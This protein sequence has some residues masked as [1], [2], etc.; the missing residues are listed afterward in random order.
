MRDATCGTRRL[1]RAV[2]WLATLL[3]VPV[4]MLG[5]QR[6]RTAVPAP[7]QELP[8]NL[9][10]FLVTLGEGKYYWEKFGHNALW[11]YDPTRGIDI[12][13]NWGTFDFGDP[14][15][16]KR[17]LTADTRYWVE[18]VPGPVFID[19]YQRSDRSITV[20]RLNFTAGQAD[21]AFAFAQWNAQDANKYYQYDYFRDNCSTRVRDVIDR[22]LGGALRQATGRRLTE[23]TYRL[24]SLRLV[25]DMKLTQFGINTALGQP[26]D[27][28]LTEWEAMFVPSTMQLA[29]REL[30]V[31]GGADGVLI[32]I[33]TD[34]RVLYESTQHQERTT[35]PG[36]AMPYLIVGLLLAAELF[37]VARAG[38]RRRGVEILFRV[39]AAVWA[40]V[41]GLLGT[42]VL[43]AWLLTQ[44]VFWFRNENL[45]LLNP[46]ALFLA[47]LVPLSLWRPR[48]TR[49][50]AIAG[51]IIA[52]LAACA[53][54]A[55]GIPAFSQD[56]L[57]MIF[58]LLPPHVAIAHALWRRARPA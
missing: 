49:A 20:Q 32:P 13:Y 2:V 21:S 1:G 56:N 33:I 39:E 46:M 7:P 26:S 41:V 34:E 44:H 10:V 37:V 24:E 31:R 28:A 6:A 50:T 47:A 53:L 15:F 11:F 29:F 27:K 22:A 3:L 23:K 40:L 58:L 42:V 35:V 19:F 17:V 52:M 14:E 12:A 45:L 54:V 5:A 25:D 57:A 16:L 51:I 18:G 9:Q 48:V 36:L 4:A 43:L 55:K 38:E 8:R 30:R